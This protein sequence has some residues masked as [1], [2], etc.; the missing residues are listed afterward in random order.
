[1]IALRWHDREDIRLDE[2]DLR[3]P[4]DPSMVEVEVDFCG[5]CGS[6]LAEYSKGPLSIR[7]SPNILTGQ[8]PPLTLGHEFSGKIVAIGSDVTS[9]RVG[10]RV[11]ADACWRCERCAAPV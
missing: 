5:I 2:V 6:D 9:V 1:M 3:L 8:Q 4:L 10:D 11:A 7:T